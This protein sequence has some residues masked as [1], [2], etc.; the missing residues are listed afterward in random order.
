[1]VRSLAGFLIR[2][3]TGELAPAEAS[4]ILASGKRTAEVPTA[5]P[6]GLFLWKV[7]Y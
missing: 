5:A 4:R 6:E 1:M 2:V 3:G 7:R